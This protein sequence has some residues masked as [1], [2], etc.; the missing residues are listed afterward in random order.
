MTSKILGKFIS[1]ESRNGFGRAGHVRI[2]TG[3]RHTGRGA[4]S[5][6]KLGAA[7]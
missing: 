3:R 6:A 4:L 5:K 2:R 7:P 1:L